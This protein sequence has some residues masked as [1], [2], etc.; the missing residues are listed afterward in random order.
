MEQSAQ[1]PINSTRTT[2]SSVISTSLMS[3]IRFQV[4]PQLFQ[5][6][7]DACVQVVVHQSMPLP[8]CFSKLATT[9]RIAAAAGP[10]V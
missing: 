4:G 1:D 8:I 10:F 7:F 3:P 9:S 2:K 6:C 5:R